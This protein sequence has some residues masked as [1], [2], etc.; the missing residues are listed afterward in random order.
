[1]DCVHHPV[2]YRMVAEGTFPDS[3]AAVPRNYTSTPP[4][5]FT[6]RCNHIFNSQMPYSIRRGAL[7]FGLVG[8]HNYGGQILAVYCF[9]TYV[10]RH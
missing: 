2:C 1:M 9:H 6:S 5:A 10:E 3:K 8:I 7:A 4:Y